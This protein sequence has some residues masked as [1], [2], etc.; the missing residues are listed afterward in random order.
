MQLIKFFKNHKENMPILGVII[1]LMTMILISFFLESQYLYQKSTLTTS[2]TQI[3]QK[4]DSTA[5]ILRDSL[6]ILH[7]SIFVLLK[8]NRGQAT[9]RH[10]IASR[11]S[12]GASKIEVME[13]SIDTSRSTTETKVV[14]R[15]TIYVQSA[16]STHNVQIKDSTGTLIEKSKISQ[17]QNHFQIS[18]F[19]GGLSDVDLTPSPALTVGASARFSWHILYTEAI[20]KTNPLSI[21]DNITTSLVAGVSLKF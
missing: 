8:S 1:F 11:D 18:V 19:G 9:Y 16:V 7:D 10:I 20:I 17:N 21:Q 4:S 14:H 6:A 3:H 15:D 13:T 5:I 2:T 12:S